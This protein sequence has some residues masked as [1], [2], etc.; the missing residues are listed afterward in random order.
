MGEIVNLRRARKQKARLAATNE[1]AARRAEFGISRA[2]R[3][4]AEL[5]KT[6]DAKRLEAHRREAP[7]RDDPA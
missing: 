3:E 5:A 1:K 6:L 4:A 2:E 7:P